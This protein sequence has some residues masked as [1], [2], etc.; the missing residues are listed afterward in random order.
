MEYQA[1]YRSYLT[2]TNV[3]IDSVPLLVN[4][5]G[6]YQYEKPLVTRDIRNDWYLQIVSSGELLCENSFIIG[7]AQFI[8]RSPNNNYVYEVKSNR[9]SYY[10][11]H[12]TGSRVKE[13]LEIVGISPDTVYKLPKNS[14]IELDKE[15]A[16][17]INELKYKRDFFEEASASMLSSILILLGRALKQTVKNKAYHANSNRLELSIGIIHQHFA[18][19]LRINELAESEHMSE[20][21]YRSMFK[22]LY[23]CSPGEYITRLRLAKACELLTST[24]L[25]V[26]ETARL[27]GYSDALYFSRIFSE[28]NGVPPL[29]YRKKYLT[30]KNQSG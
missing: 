21:R 19:K 23:G 25:S 2:D 18:C 11:A 15:F 29:K 24:N 13:L 27:C 4:C 9:V 22:Q 10:C 26:S 28:K 14:L 7:E 8:L 3:R 30:I 1:Y 12:F 6:I 17:I 5:V 20:S 16:R